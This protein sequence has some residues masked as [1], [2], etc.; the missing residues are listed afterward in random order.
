MFM[1]CIPF[2]RYMAGQGTGRKRADLGFV[3][4]AFGAM[5]MKVTR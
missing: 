2:A 5:A 4:Y 1:P 3:A